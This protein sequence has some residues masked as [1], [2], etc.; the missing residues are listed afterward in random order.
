MKNPPPPLLVRELYPRDNNAW[1]WFEVESMKQSQY[2]YS[3][4][5]LK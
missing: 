4:E 1:M 2:I 3:W 5:N